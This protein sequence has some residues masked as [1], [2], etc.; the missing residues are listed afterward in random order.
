MKLTISKKDIVGEGPKRLEVRTKSGSTLSI[1]FESIEH[2]ETQV[3]ISLPANAR[4]R[5]QSKKVLDQFK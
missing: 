3:Q 2:G 4:V 5:G 1:P